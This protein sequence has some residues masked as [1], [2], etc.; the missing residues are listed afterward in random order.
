MTENELESILAESILVKSE[1]S[2]LRSIE[3][4]LQQ[5]G[6]KENFVG[7]HL[8]REVSILNKLLLSKQR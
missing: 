8:V 6:E 4:R 7:K 1:F 3:R 2:Q 5:R